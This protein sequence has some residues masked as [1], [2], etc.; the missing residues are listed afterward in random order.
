MIGERA[1]RDLCSFLS[2]CTEHSSVEEMTMGLVAW[3][4]LTSTE[5]N[6]RDFF[7]SLGRLTKAHLTLLLC[8]H[9]LFFQETIPEM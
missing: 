7:G 6:M 4:P 9:G 5:L 2:V 1:L 8:H 3:P